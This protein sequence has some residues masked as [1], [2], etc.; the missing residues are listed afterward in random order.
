MKKL[1]QKDMILTA[2]KRGETL[3][4]LDALR[5]FGVY[6]LSQRIGELKRDGHPIKSAPHSWTTEF[7][8]HKTISKY[9]IET[10][11][12]QAELGL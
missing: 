4:V 11:K 3:T 7:G 10:E 6:A 12:K 8:E 1:T 5:R 9:W 2:L